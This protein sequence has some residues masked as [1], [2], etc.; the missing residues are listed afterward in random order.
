MKRAPHQRP[1]K[2]TRNNMVTMGHLF[3]SRTMLLGRKA[4]L[5][6]AVVLV[7]SL[8]FLHSLPVV[9]AAGRV[10]VEEND[11]SHHD[12]QLQDWTTIF[13][14]D[15]DD[16]TSPSWQDFTQGGTGVDTALNSN[17]AYTYASSPGSIRLRDNS[18]MDSSVILNLKAAAAAKGISLA[19][20][21]LY[22]I[23]F[24][25]Y[26]RSF[27]NTE[28]FFLEY[29]PE[30]TSCPEGSWQVL[31]N[32][33][34]CCSETEMSTK[35]KCRKQKECHFDNDEPGEI[36]VPLPI[37]GS[38]PHLRFRAD[39]SGNGD[40]L[41][42]D[43]VEIMAKGT[44]EPAPTTN[45]SAR[46]SV[47]PT[48]KPT[49]T[50]SD[51]PS[52]TPTTKPTVT[53]SD[54][55]SAA[56]TGKPTVTGSDGPSAAPTAKPTVTGSDGPSAV[57]TAKP[58]VTGSDGPSAVPTAKPTV[59]GS[60]GPSAVPTHKPS[61]TSS[62]TA[63]MPSS[64]PSK[65]PSPKPSPEPTTSSSTTSMPSSKPSKA[66]SPK[67]SPAPTTSSPTSMPSSK[68]SKAPS[69]EPSPAPTPEC[70]VN[71]D[72]AD[73]TACNGDEIC[74]NET[75]TCQAGT[76]PCEDPAQPYCLE[77]LSSYGHTCVECQ[78]HSHCTDTS[79]C[80]PRH[81][82]GD[83]YCYDATSPC[84][85]DETCVVVNESSFQCNP[86][87]DAPSQRPSSPPSK[88][89]SPT[90]EPLLSYVF[91]NDCTEVS[92]HDPVTLAC[93]GSTPLQR[94]EGDW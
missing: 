48:A 5:T 41:Y 42:I 40:F 58:T 14:N 91:D 17:R 25:Y 45:P 74:D 72:C 69:P 57:P 22:Q 89:A 83:G 21:D 60:D 47:T 66:P 56:P 28:D 36:T 59:T 73:S 80:L 20:Y 84:A 51:E 37:S 38:D 11:P 68:P 19:D 1:K 30:G 6:V 79:P 46:P 85:Q 7:S 27:E 2:D 49:V 12:R 78:S 63:S 35:R 75:L 88:S 65:A 87:T 86:I 13:V 76:N 93:P 18:K 29:C 62:P 64:K 94:C 53:G 23:K 26:V 39:A 82:H 24:W 70:T 16:G 32:W 71:A 9:S 92:G 55:P 50:E 10:V 44:G 54:G 43:Q 34:R 33:Q 77:N 81:C 3:P 31:G 8:L 67:P 61:P 90:V 52:V 4:P 15:F